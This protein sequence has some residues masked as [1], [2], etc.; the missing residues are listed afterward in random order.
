MHYL[1]VLPL[2]TVT[3]HD[4]TLLDAR[5]CAPVSVAAQLQLHRLS[6]PYL[7]YIVPVLGDLLMFDC[8]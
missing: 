7:A 3:F 8:R 2:Q 6:L 4:S 5:Y 1:F